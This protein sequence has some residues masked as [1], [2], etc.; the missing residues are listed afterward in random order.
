[1]DTKVTNL[2]VT[3]GFGFIGSN[4]IN[5]YFQKNVDNLTVL[6]NID[7]LYYAANEG[8]I[9]DD[10]KTH[11]KYVFIK[12][13]ICN[14]DLITHVLKEYNI[15][16]IIHF[17]AQSAVDASFTNSLQYTKD[18]VYGTHNLLECCRL[19]GKL[20]KF[21]H[22]STDEVYGD[23]KL[24]DKISKNET[25]LLCPNNPY[26][27]TKAAAEMI[28][29]SY[30]RCY[31]MPIIITRGNNVYGPNQYPEKII[32]KF[33]SLLRNNKKVTVHGDGQYVRAF[34]HSYDAVKA[35][36]LILEQG[37]IGEIYNIGCHDEYSILDI[38]RKIIR[39]VKNTTDYERW[40]E[41]V[42]DRIYNDIRYYIDIRKLE[43][44]GWKIE[45][46]FD[47]ELIKL[48]R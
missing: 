24:S 3:G 17:A 12:S 10:I 44:L 5:Y 13:D 18:N 1:M 14:A 7:C 8:N 32:P 16:H 19:Y 30:A 2:M 11:K 41:Y 36:E 45:K 31:N 22:V 34:L 23:S 48:C 28:V 26:A 40:I 42:S 46:N 37:T 15:T 47:E 27:A 39:L 29:G 9:I 6:V 25:S 35:F 43:N 21:I 20:V 4:F 38:T 33:I